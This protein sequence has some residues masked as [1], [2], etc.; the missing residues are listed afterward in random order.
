MIIGRS[1]GESSPNCGNPTRATSS[2]RRLDENKIK[3]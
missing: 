1:F 2:D 3:V